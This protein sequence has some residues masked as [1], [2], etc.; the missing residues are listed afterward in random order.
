MSQQ[1][2]VS[3]GGVDVE[4]LLRKQKSILKNLRARV[5][6]GNFTVKRIALLNGSTMTYVK[7]LMEIFLL[8]SGVAP[9]FY[10][11][12]YNKF[13]EDAM[14]GNPELDQFEPDIVVIFTSV[15]N[16]SELPTV[17]DYAQ[18]VESKLD[19]E[20]Q[21]FVDIWQNLDRKFHA[22]LIQNNFDL[23]YEMPL[24][25]LEAAAPFGLNRFVERLNERFAAYADAHDNFYIHDLH[26]LSARIGLDAWHNRAKY[27]AYKFAMSYECMPAVAFNIAKLIRALLGKSKK[28]LVLD[29][30]NTLWGGV[31]ADDGVDN[32]QIG[33]ET[34]EAESFADFQRYVKALKRRGIILAVCSKND[35]DVAKSGFTHPDSILSVDDF[36][37]FVANWEPKNVNIE[38]IAA[39]LNIGLDSLVF[40]DDNPVERAIVREN[41]PTVAVP[42]VDP[43]DVSSY[44]RSIELNGYFETVAISEDDRRRS[45][46]YRERSARRHAATTFGNYD[47][48]LRSLEMRAEIAPFRSVYFDRIA[49]LTNKT[50]QFNLTTRRCTRAEIE[51]MAN[52]ARYVTLYGRLVDKFGDN[53]LVTVVVGERRGNELHIVLW[54]MSCRVLKRGLEDT[55]LDCLVT[56]ARARGLDRLIGLYIP[57]SKNKM[58]EGM[59][60]GMGFQRLSSTD[61]GVQ[62]ALD[63]EGYEP[64]GKFITVEG[65]TA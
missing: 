32:L 1:Q 22:T 61:A 52:D 36:A 62:W 10:E 18:S 35:A 59:Y 46:Q 34:P 43:N 65:A 42:E 50:N 57:T 44:I 49:Q 4:T 12:E 16:L 58:V 13:Y 9:I 39:E 38:R 24:G 7:N 47:D 33:H 40:I 27:Y 15:V 64:R 30:D 28:C 37:A 31:I 41:L 45:E 56:E 14:F 60:E 25:N 29:L 63:V 53:G 20:Y 5:A 21:K 54:L 48:F 8:Q 23:P 2:N 19:R 17:D 55:M 3:V 6:D 26:G 11:S 51:T